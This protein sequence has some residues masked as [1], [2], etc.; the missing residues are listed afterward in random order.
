VSAVLQARVTAPARSPS[1]AAARTSRTTP[2]RPAR[3]APTAHVLTSWHNRGAVPLAPAL[4]LGDAHDRLE[5]EADRVAR[6]VL[7]S[8][9]PVDPEARPDRARTGDTRAQLVLRSPPSGGATPA[10]PI[11]NAA[12]AAP[13]QP[14]DAGSRSFFE[15][16]LG[17]DLGAVRV[18][19]GALAGESARAV[20]ARAFTVGSHIVFGHGS[21]APH[22]ASGRGLLAHEL[23]HV[24]Q[25]DRSQV[26]RVQRA[27]IWSSGYTNPYPNF[28]AEV[29]SNKAQQWWPSST[30]FE[31]TAGLAGGGTGASTLAALLGFIEQQAVGSISDLGIIGHGNATSASLGGTLKP[32]DNVYFKDDAIIDA[33]TLAR[34]TVAPRVAK[35][36]DRFKADGTI[37][38]YACHS[39]ASKSLLEA[40]SGAFN[41]CAR[42]FSEELVSCLWWYET[43]PPTLGGRGRMS[44]KSKAGTTVDC[45]GFA[46]DITKLTPD[47]VACKGK[48]VVKQP[49]GDPFEGLDL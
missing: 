45:E 31:K 41:V 33:V 11:V 28:G 20:D 26:R 24:V 8:A 40:V 3:A 22:T 19:V 21:Y 10:P 43:K 4:V 42:G 38:L 7:R 13:A 46:N 44:P 17:H 16:R 48:L 32:G 15:P 34:P 23:V 14:L 27:M 5:H 2:P 6:H 47:T 1:P 39:G 25:Q 29:L 37:T 9:G 36:R 35:V 30:D 12:L 49:T 18:H